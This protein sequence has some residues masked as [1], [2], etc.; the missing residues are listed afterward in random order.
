[1]LVVAFA[2]HAHAELYRWVDESGVPHYTADLESIPPAMRASA[3]MSLSPHAPDG[4]PQRPVVDPTILPYSAGGP[5][6]VTAAINGAPVRLL[7][8]TGADR[9]IISSS[10]A[11]RAGLAGMLGSAVHIRGVGG[12]VTGVEV[13]VSTL[14]VAGSR[15]GNLR[16]IVHDTGLRNADGLLGRD[17]LDAFTLTVDAAGGRATIVPR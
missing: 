14:D 5:L 9:T 6:I 3:T 12:R 4:V 10:A 16:V 8:D 17:V 11:S 2:S 15:I 1:V 13:V 7:V